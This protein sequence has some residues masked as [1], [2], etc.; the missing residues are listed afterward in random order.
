VKA[1]LFNITIPNYI[2]LQLFGRINK[3]FFFDGPFATVKMKEVPEPRLPSQEWVK[4][5]TRFCG[6]CGSDLNLLMVKDSTMASPFTSFPC[7]F[8]HELCGDVVEV[9]NSVDTCVIGD[10]VTV[11]PALSCVPRGISPVCP[12][13][14]AGRPG[15]CE[16]VAEGGFSPGM[17][18]G[19]CKDLGGGFAEYMVVHK[20]QVFRVPAGVSAESATLTEPLAVGIQAVLDNK[21]VDRDKVL[22]IGGG[23]IGT[24]IVKAIRA[25]DIGCSITVVE[26]SAF[27]A[28]YVK[29]S[30]ADHVISGNI[31]EAAEK[32]AGAKVYKPMM[33]ERIVEGGF[34]KVFDT[35]GHSPTLQMALI[36]TTGCG[37]ISLVG[38]GN[39]VTFDPTPLWLKLQTLKGCYAYGYNDTPGGRKHAFEIVLEFMKSRKIQVEDMLTHT[40][41]IEQYKD[42]VVVNMNKGMNRAI[43]TAIRF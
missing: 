24:M 23:V 2:A 38:I 13:C 7:I 14:T 40:F 32:I 28:D 29:R 34:D 5:K 39:K 1:L 10:L 20:S 12:V 33:G 17:F 22:V 19:I 26:P 4:I 27:S 9:G 43:K 16:R 11:N 15:N 25:L 3:K 36:V 41:P 42:L 8:G 35:V 6:F 31:I 18:T 30:G 37:A 21:P